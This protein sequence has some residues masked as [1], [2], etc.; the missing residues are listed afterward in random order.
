MWILRTSIS[1]Q[2]NEY[3]IKE[4]MSTSFIACLN[5][6][7]RQFYS[8]SLLEQL[9][10]FQTKVLGKKIITCL[11]WGSYLIKTSTVS[12][13]MKMTRPLHAKFQCVQTVWMDKWFIDMMILIILGWSVSEGRGWYHCSCVIMAYGVWYGLLDNKDQ[14]SSYEG[15]QSNQ[16]QTTTSTD[17]F[18]I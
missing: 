10:A 8:D 18:Y 3:F 6:L 13:M 15:T 4:G 2:T 7:H 11:C 16:W 9:R 12:F 5:R 14:C 17:W 1:K